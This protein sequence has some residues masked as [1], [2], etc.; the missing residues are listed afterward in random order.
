LD[1]DVVSIKRS[2]A[3]DGIILQVGI[4]I[5]GNFLVETFS[6]NYRFSF[7]IKHLKLDERVI[8]GGI[9]EA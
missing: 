6:L 2:D 8:G 9:R 4:E 1:A 7:Q 3:M 5:Y